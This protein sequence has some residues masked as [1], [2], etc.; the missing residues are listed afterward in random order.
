[1]KR[2]N[3]KIGSKIAISAAI[4]ILLVAGL[5]VNQHLTN[6]AIA[7]EAAFVNQNHFNKADATA[8]ASAVQLNY[9]AVRDIPLAWP[10]PQVDKVL[11]TLRAGTAEAT[12]HFDSAMNRA[13]R[14]TT[15]AIYNNLKVQTAAYLAAATELATARKTSLA[16]MT[17][18]EAAAA[19]LAK[20][21]EAML[22]SPV[23]AGLA[24]QR[25]VQA[26]LRRANTALGA[27]QAALWRF[28][29]TAEAEQQERA[30]REAERTIETLRRARA[31]ADQAEAASGIDALMAAAAN[32]KSMTEEAIRLEAAKVRVRD[33]RVQPIAGEINKGV[34]HAVAT[35]I[36]YL[37]MRR[38][39]LK[40][41]IE[42]AG[43]MVPALGAAVVLVLIGSVVF[44]ML[45]IARPIAAMTA[46][47]KNLASGHFDVILPGLK[48]RDE[49]GGM[50]QAVEAFKVKAIERAHL[51]AEHKEAETRAA[52]AAR[53]AEMQRLADTFE[54][55]IAN[56][57]DTVSSAS[58]NLEAAASTLTHTADTTQQLSGDVA[59]ASEQASVNVQSVATATDELYTS[60]GEISRQVQ[61]SND[62]AVEAVQQAQDTDA[63]INE[64]SKAAGRIGDVVKLITAVAE[65][66][67]LLALNA[68]IEAARAG[69]AGRGFAV[70][71]AE[72]KTLA[73]Q[74]ANATGE[75]SA[76]ITGMQAATEESVLAIKEIRTTIGRISSIATSIAT[77]I[78]E[79]GAATQ[80]ISRNVAQAAKGT[81]EVATKIGD[82]NR[83]AAQTGVASTQVFSS[84]QELSNQGSKLKAEVARF[85]ETVRAA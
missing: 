2:L 17:K 48:R 31:L 74:T 29:V 72:V 59:A 30:V 85:L 67:N 28:A 66:T 34:E 50:A 79:Q 9:V 41:L 1:M 81:A 57:V 8:G 60:I 68:T 25:E 18:G 71:A 45:D 15:K 36:G 7:V 52:A 13:N 16:A 80:E 37:E 42:R 20:A 26:N 21:L 53:K 70:V 54:A 62:I 27:A 10:A 40:A 49:I 33:E 73:N 55:A 65:Q 35:A 3:L 4:G 56:V 84:A 75:I 14:A 82:V 63:R 83:G 24:S 39:N 47:M 78:E 5:V 44:C 11:E 6:A 51:E 19:D 61:E 32:I 38:A 46:A 64:L 12:R 23:L 77:A 76:H 22:G 58:T 43:W 69:E